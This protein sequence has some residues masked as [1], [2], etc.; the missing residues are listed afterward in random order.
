MSS[1]NK[2]RL[3]KRPRFI[4]ID[5]ITRDLMRVNI[6]SNTAANILICDL[7]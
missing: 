7:N 2:L 3:F 4:I 1:L 6:C 5:V